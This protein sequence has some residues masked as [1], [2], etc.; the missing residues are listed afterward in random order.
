RGLAE[1]G[2]QRALGFDEEAVGRGKAAG[3]H[4]RHC[5]APRGPS[6]VPGFP[7]LRPFLPRAIIPLLCCSRFTPMRGKVPRLP[8]NPPDQSP[9]AASF[10]MTTFTAKNETVQRD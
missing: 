6:P 10:A 9:Q 2:F 3:G 8:R 1:H 7:D 4:V 5:A